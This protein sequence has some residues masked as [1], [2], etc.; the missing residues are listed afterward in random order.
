MEKD[1]A[2]VVV[3]AEVDAVMVVVMKT[4]VDADIATNPN[5]KNN[6]NEKRADFFVPPFLF[7]SIGY[8]DIS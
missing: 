3:T 6:K 4:T 2:V 1:A 5:L 7:L 8:P